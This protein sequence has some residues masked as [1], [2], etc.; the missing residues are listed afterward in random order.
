MFYVRIKEKSTENEV[1]CSFLSALIVYICWGVEGFVFLL[2]DDT[3]LPKIKTI[4]VFIQ[5]KFSDKAKRAAYMT[6][7]IREY[8]FSAYHVFRHRSC[9]RV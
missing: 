6:C 2:S 1:R 9:T 4:G 7:F 8:G 5:R 3:I